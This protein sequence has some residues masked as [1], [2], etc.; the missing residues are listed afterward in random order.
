MTRSKTAYGQGVGPLMPGV[1]STEFPYYSQACMP[2]E[3]SI[4][5]LTSH[6]L[7]RLELVLKQETAPS[8][9]A[10]IIIET[11]LGEGGYVAAPPAF[12]RGVRELCDKHDILL[13]IDEVQAGFG[14]TG[15]MF[16]IEHSGVRP[17]LMVFAKG[18][19]NGYPLSGLAG[20]K[21]LMDTMPP[22]SLGG[23]Y[24]G[25]AVA[26]AAAIA[27]IQVMRDEGVLD[28]VAVRHDQLVQGLEQLRTS[29]PAG[30][31]IEQIRGDGLMIGV[32]FNT[33]KGQPVNAKLTQACLQRNMLL[34]STSSFDVV[35]WIPPL[36]VSE[37]EL[38]EA[39]RI[40]GESLE[41]AAREANL[42]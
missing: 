2:L 31:L 14:R 38:A 24:A 34:L 39:I 42:L 3:T 11:V 30:K 35:R 20:R 13:V 21:E 33:P 22:G 28:N 4:E 7:E 37:S 8:D 25:N 36:T 9:T 1:F 18:L 27:T 16:A 41:Q 6:A 26:C 32:Q 10:A 19:A 23:T 29:S 15:K 40:F 17:D 12:L 5:Q